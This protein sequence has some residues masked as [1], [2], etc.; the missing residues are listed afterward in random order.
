MTPA[1]TRAARALLNWTEDELAGR[2]SL[3]VADLRAHEAGQRD[4]APAQ[5]AGL[6]GALAR[7]G[8]VLDDGEGVRLGPAGRG[9][10]EGVRLGD[11]TT[12]N[13]R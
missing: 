7:A 9:R 13:D 12:E 4:L 11:L 6:A 1:Q 3:T 5:G 10:D 8:I 2:A